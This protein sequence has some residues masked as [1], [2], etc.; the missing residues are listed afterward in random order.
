[1][2]SSI[3][4]KLAVM[5]ESFFFDEKL[6]PPL[7][8]ACKNGFFDIASV[9]IEEDGVDVNQLGGRYNTTPL[10]VAA[11][12]NRISTLEL[13]LDAKADMTLRDDRGFT[14]SQLASAA[15]YMQILS[16]LAINGD[17]LDAPTGVPTL[18]CKRGGRLCPTVKLSV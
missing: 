12:L 3:H 6:Q 15:G 17:D 7:W 8:Q 4:G 13:L 16:I 1:M 9:E 14:A 18:S 11:W 5:P 10:M 2:L